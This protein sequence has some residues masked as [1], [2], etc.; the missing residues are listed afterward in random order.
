MAG[1]Y[2]WSPVAEGSLWLIT[3]QSWSSQSYSF[4]EIN[5]AN[6]LSAVWKLILLWS[7]QRR[8]LAFKRKEWVMFAIPE[9]SGKSGHSKFSNAHMFPSHLRVT[10]FPNQGLNL[11][12]ADLPGFRI[13]PYMILHYQ[14]SPGPDLLLSFFSS[15][16]RWEILCMLPR[17]LSLFALN[18]W[19]IT[20]GLSLSF[21]NAVTTP[22]SSSP[23]LYSYN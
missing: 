16:S 4:K 9:C 1:N 11:G 15:C 20:L 21:Y 18:W 22:S 14:L 6:N 17:K 10:L 23:I 2:G 5:P 3:E 8:V 13:K 7:S 19:F 12:V